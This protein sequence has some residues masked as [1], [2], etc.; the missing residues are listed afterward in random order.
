MPAPARPRRHAAHWRYGLLFGGLTVAGTVAA[1]AGGRW[2]PVPAYCLS[3]N[4]VTL[5]AFAYDKAIAGTRRTRVPEIILHALACAGGSPGA[6]VGQYVL[7]HKTAKRL[8]QVVFWI[9]VVVQAI[10][11]YTYFV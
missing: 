2:H 10:A 6:L 11:L 5:L 1:L 4:A 7:R 3:I 8:F 9:I